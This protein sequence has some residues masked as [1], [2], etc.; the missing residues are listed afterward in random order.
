MH[1]QCSLS[2]LL[3]AVTLVE[4]AVASQNDVPILTGI[5]I[6]AADSQVI[7]TA[8]NL[9]L[10]IKSE[11]EAYV[12]R[13][14]KTVVDGKLLAAII[15]KLPDQPIIF[16]IIDNQLI[17]TA[18]NVEFALNVLTEEDFPELPQAEQVQFS[19]PANKLLKMIKN[20]IYACG[21][22]DRRPFL[23]GILFETIDN[24]LNFVAT[25]INRLSYYAVKLDT[26]VPNTEMLVPMKTMQELQR[27]LPNDTTPINISFGEKYLIFEYGANKITTRLIED[28][29]PQYR[30]LFPN[31]EPIQITV[32]RQMLIA[33][34][35]RAALIDSDDGTQVVI[36]EAVDGVLEISTPT[37]SKGKSQEKLNVEHQGENGRAAFSAKYILDMLKAADAEQIFFHFNSDL[38]Q[39]LMQADNDEDQ[40]YILMPVR[41]S[42]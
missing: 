19:L 39:C 31:H 7:L 20:T 30:G 18:G 6:A 16:E 8:T 15:K 12:N 10:G 17:I 41:L 9:E 37:G 4:K 28:R 40:K 14:D 23:N 42:Q 27:S 25:D 35:E 24:Q 1:F 26:N 38:Q 5:H 29:F 13:A 22:D 11:F 2:D 34:V 21:K 32:N 36:F 3:P 33:A